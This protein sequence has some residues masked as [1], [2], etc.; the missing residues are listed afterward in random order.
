MRKKDPTFS[1]TNTTKGKLPSLPFKDL[2]EEVLG[3]AFDLSLVFIGDKRSRTLN[4]R[5]LG[6]D[7]AT[8]V[9]AFPLS[10]NSGEIFVNLK[11]VERSHEKFGMSKNAFCAY[12]VVH[13][14]LHLKG[15]PHGSRM[16]RAEKKVLKKFNLTS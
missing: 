2:K 4:R 5:F 14:M 15:F 1:I 11:E 6:K 16:E 7:K 8:N 12:L 10:N 13:G 3:K 9:L